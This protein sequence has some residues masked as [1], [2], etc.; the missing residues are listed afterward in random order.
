MLTINFTIWNSVDTTDIDSKLRLHYE[1]EYNKEIVPVSQI[2]HQGRWRRHVAARPEGPKF[3]GQKAKA[4]V[5]F[6]GRWAASSLPTSC[7]VREIW[8]SSVSSPSGVLGKAL[9]EIDL[10]VFLIPQKAFSTTI[11]GSNSIWRQNYWGA[12]LHIVPPGPKFRRSMS[13]CAS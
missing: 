7:R 9:T 11:L 8:E 2:F 5:G 6:L 3:E 12:T 10:C 4:G 1:T 13:L